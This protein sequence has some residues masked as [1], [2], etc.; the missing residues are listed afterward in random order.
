[1]TFKCANNSAV[2]GEKMLQMCLQFIFHTFHAGSRQ[3]GHQL[4]Q[5]L[6]AA[7]NLVPATSFCALSFVAPR[8]RQSD[9][10]ANQDSGNARPLLWL[11]LFFITPH[12]K[13]D[14]GEGFYKKGLPPYF[15][16]VWGHRLTIFGR[17]KKLLTEEQNMLTVEKKQ[18]IS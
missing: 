12:W 15:L 13:T 5:Q 18:I 7:V 6:T 4:L 11:H 8:P 1:M 16:W 10:L 9:A 2:L 17:N 14:K 3:E